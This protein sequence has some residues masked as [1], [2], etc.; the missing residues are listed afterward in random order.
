MASNI[1]PGKR[2]FCIRPSTRNPRG[3]AQSARG[4]RATR[5]AEGCPR[6]SVAHSASG[7]RHAQDVLHADLC[8]AT[9]RFANA[10]AGGT[11]PG[12]AHGRQ[13][14][15]HALRG[16]GARVCRPAV[17]WNGR[18][19]FRCTACLRQGDS[20]AV[21]TAGPRSRS[22]NRGWKAARRTARTR[23]WP[24]FFSSVPRWIP[25][26]PSPCPRSIPRPERT[27]EA[28]GRPRRT[29]LPYSP[30]LS[31]PLVM[32]GPASAP[33]CSRPRDGL[34]LRAASAGFAGSG[35]PATRS[36]PDARAAGR[37]LQG[38]EH[39]APGRRRGAKQP[40]CHLPQ[41]RPPRPGSRARKP[42]RKKPF[43]PARAGSAAG[44]GDAAIRT[45]DYTLVSAR[46]RVSGGE[47]F[48]DPGR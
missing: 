24:R 23:T 2:T 41:H 30:F 25:R 27:S 43:L 35:C 17:T 38:P 42:C 46:Q 16:R 28:P 36:S 11:G 26:F 32:V 47:P 15:V 19:P 29:V 1:T 48:G 33:P 3:D 5:G 13:R 40:V 10:R 18:S 39:G 7:L 31:K 14:A 34:A 45:V 22:S 21:N 37:H 12:E 20:C 6:A 4:R 44:R 8:V 9:G